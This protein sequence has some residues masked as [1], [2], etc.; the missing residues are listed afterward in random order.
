MIYGVCCLFFWT[1]RSLEQKP[2]VQD[3]YGAA[4]AV[5]P[6]HILLTNIFSSCK[7][8]NITKVLLLFLA[9]T[10]GIWSHI[11]LTK[12]DR[13]FL[14]TSS[15][16]KTF[17]SWA[18]PHYVWVEINMLTFGFGLFWNNSVC[19]YYGTAVRTLWLA[20]VTFT[21]RKMSRILT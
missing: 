20:H 13:V 3:L 6:T 7:T 12:L 11:V 5:R 9:W 4:N 14:R 8:W 21:C 2:S 19:V 1:A 18:F 16:C 10:I 17:R 15:L